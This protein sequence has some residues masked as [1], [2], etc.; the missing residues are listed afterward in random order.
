MAAKSTKGAV[1]KRKDVSTDSS[2]IPWQ[3]RPERLLEDQPGPKGKSG[4]DM[5]KPAGGA[6]Y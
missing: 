4:G 1:S 3:G 5:K 2:G 6:N